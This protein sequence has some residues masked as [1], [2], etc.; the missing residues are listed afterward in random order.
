MVAKSLCS[1]LKKKILTSYEVLT[2]L[3]FIFGAAILLGFLLGHAHL[4]IVSH[5]SSWHTWRHHAWVLPPHLIV[6]GSSWVS[7]SA[8]LLSKSSSRVL[9]SSSLVILTILI[10]VGSLVAILAL[11]SLQSVLLK[12]LWNWIAR[13][14]EFMLSVS[15]VA[16]QTE[17]ADSGRLKMSAPLGFV[18]LVDFLILAL[19]ILSHLVH[20]ILAELA[21]HWHTM[22]LHLAV[23]VPHHELLLVHN[24]SV[25]LIK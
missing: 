2:H 9:G 7:S 8:S 25:L 10:E 6:H 17:L 4:W 22:H 12:V 1:G 13:L 20:L 24:W 18:F 23:G 5:H 3:S 15:E 16:L 11:D 19:H 14:S 21:H